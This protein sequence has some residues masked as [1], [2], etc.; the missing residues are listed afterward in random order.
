MTA[1]PEFFSLVNLPQS[2]LDQ[3]AARIHVFAT[4]FLSNGDFRGSGTFATVHGKKGILTANHVWQDIRA[5]GAFV[6]LVVAD[7]PHR[8]ELPISALNPWVDLRPKESQWGPDFQ[9]LQLP[10][11]HIATIEARKTFVELTEGADAKIK[12]TADDIGFMYLAGCPAE[13][14]RQSDMDYHGHPVR[15]IRGGFVTTLSKQ[16][17]KDGFDYLETTEGEGVAGLPKSYGGVSG[18]GLWRVILSKRPSAPIT[19][20]II[21]DFALAGV[22][23]YEFAGPGMPMTLRYHG[24]ETVYSVL[25]R[26]VSPNHL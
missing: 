1:A 16:F 2:L 12:M 18:A 25:N 24:P 21:K 5:R 4:S 15:E 10:P 7:G 11:A 17:Q 19:D 6:E 23:F 22:A 13:F 3:A 14:V 9:F 8:F 26:L 20:A